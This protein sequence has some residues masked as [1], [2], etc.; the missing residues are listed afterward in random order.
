MF[1]RLENGTIVNTKWIVALVPDVYFDH[2]DNPIPRGYKIYVVNSGPE[3]SRPA[4]DL[5]DGLSA[6]TNDYAEL[7]K[8]LEKEQGFR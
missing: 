1:Y 8:I 2:D 4:R 5:S 3:S 7:I 6:S